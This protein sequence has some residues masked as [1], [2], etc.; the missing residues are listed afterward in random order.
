MANGSLSDSSADD[1]AGGFLDGAGSCL[2]VTR[3]KGGKTGL[4]LGG[5]TDGFFIVQQVP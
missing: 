1:A 3:M 5:I 2:F 4:F